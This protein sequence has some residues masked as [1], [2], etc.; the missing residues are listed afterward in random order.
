M[1]S[2]EMPVVLRV[3]TAARRVRDERVET[4]AAP[5]GVHLLEHAHAEFERVALSPE[6]MHERAAAARDGHDLATSARE[7]ADRR[8]VDRRLE[9]GL[10]AAGQQADARAALAVRGKHASAVVRAV[11]LRVVLT[12]HARSCAGAGGASPAA[13]APARARASRATRAGNRRANGRASGTSASAAANRRGYGSTAASERAQPALEQRPPIRLLDVH[14]RVIDEV[15]VVDA[16]R[17]RRHARETRKAAIEVRHDLRARR[18]V[19]LEH[20]LDQVDPAARAVELVSEQHVRRTGRSAEAAV[21]ALAQDRLARGDARIL[22][23]RGGE[24]RLHGPSALRS[25]EPARAQ[26]AGGIERVLHAP[27]SQRERRRAAG[28]T[29]RSRRARRAAL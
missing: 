2:E 27:R 11:E 14:A 26:A 13:S 10:H 18:P 16:R 9:D 15:L 1:I 19:V 25:A 7:N 12:V 4:A 6:M 20:L 21:H 8:R 17:A 28:G 5:L 24:T 23:L 3:R 29:P 22:Q